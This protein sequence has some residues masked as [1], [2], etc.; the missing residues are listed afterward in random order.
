M[1]N[2][3]TYS[4]QVKDF[5]HASFKLKPFNTVSNGINLDT[6][7]INELLIMFIKHFLRPNNLPSS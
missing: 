5:N 3:N 2:E 4:F 1:S 7:S 6:N